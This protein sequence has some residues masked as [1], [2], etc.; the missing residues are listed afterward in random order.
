M[1][2][3][4]IFCLLLQSCSYGIPN[5]GPSSEA[6][7]TEFKTKMNGFKARALGSEKD[8]KCSKEKLDEDFERLM[9]SV[10]K[11]SC[12]Q[13][14][15]S[16]DK[17]EFSKNSCPKIKTEGLFDRVVKKTIQ[18]EKAK[19]PLTY[20]QQK[21]DPEF[22]GL[23]TEAGTY[24]KKI[25]E[26][27]LE[28][29]YP[30]NTRIDLIAD[31]VENVLMPIR[32]LVVIKR[33]Y[34][35]K[36]EDGSEYF[37]NLQ[38]SLPFDMTHDLNTQQMGIL[39][40]GRN[41]STTPTYMEITKGKG[42]YGYQLAFSATDIIRHDVITLL[43]A[44]T[45]KNYVLAMKWMTLH[46][47]LSQ[48]SLYDTM[49]DSKDPVVIPNSCQNQLNGNLPAL[50]KFKNEEGMGDQFLES[51]IASHG[52]AYKKDDTAFLDYYIEN[53]KK[54][55]TQEGYSGLIPF[56][57]YKNAKMS[58]KNAGNNRPQFDDI[59]H[60]DAIM[61]VKLPEAMREF[62]G[63]AKNRNT[64]KKEKITYVG[65]EEFKSILGSYKADE[66][67]EYKSLNG[68]T[69]QIYPGKQ[70]LSPFLFELMKQNGF[71]D[72][73][74][75]ITERLK[76]K[77]VGRKALI[78]FPGM[79]SAPVWRDWSLRV[80]ADLFYQNQNLPT[81]SDFHLITRLH[82]D[83][84]KTN[85]V[86][87]ANKLCT[88]NQ[89]QGL[90]NFLSEFRSGEKY[91]PTRRLEERQFQAIYPLLGFIWASLR[92]DTEFLAEAKPFELNFLLEQMSVGNPWARLKF[93]Y[94]I[95]LDLLEYQREGIDPVYESKNGVYKTQCDLRDVKLKYEHIAEAGKI[96]GL[97][98][99]L[100]FNF[101]EKILSSDE[102]KFIWKNIVADFDHRNAQLFSVTSGDKDFYKIV[103]DVSY[104]TI[105]DEKSALNTGAN[106]SEKTRQE[107]S[108]VAKSNEA[109]IGDFFLKLYKEKNNIEKQQKLYEDFSKINGIDTVY[110]VK[111][112]F[113]AVDESYKKPIYKD[114]LKQAARARKQ[115]IM[116]HLQTFCAMD[117]NN[118]KEL[119]NI[120][121]SASKAQNE[122][123]QAAGLP[124]IPENVLKDI[125]EMSPE[126]FRDM[127]WGIGSG[128]A[129]MAAIAIG[130]ACTWGTGGLCLP[131]AATMVAAGVSSVGIQIKL[132]G[133]ELERKA[134]ADLS[135]KKVK[136]ME[137]LGF[138]NAGSSDEVH[139]GYIWAVVEAA[140]IVPMMGV[141]GRSVSLGPKLAAISARAI[142]QQT[143]KLAFKTA[144]KTAIAEEEAR[145]ASY[146]LRL[147]SIPKMLGLDSKSIDLAKIK[148]DKIRELYISKEI[149]LD[150]MLSRIGKV[151]DPIRRAKLAYAKTI[152]SE[153]GRV[154]VKN[155]EL[156][157]TQTAR[158]VSDYFAGNAS[159]MLRLIK[160]YSGETLSRSIRIMNEINAPE[161]IQKRIPILGGLKD[162]FLRMRNESLAKNAS[163]IL[164][165]EKELAGVGNAPGNLE[166]YV[167]K[168]IDDLT[169]IF[170]DI[171]MR[172]R[173]LLYIMQ[174]Q[175]MPDINF[176]EGRKFPILSII[177]EGQTMKKIFTARARLV[178]ESYKADAR[179][180]FKLKR[181]VQS[182]TTFEAF[183][184]FQYS[185]A[186]MAN[187][188]TGAET[189][190]IMAEYHN[191][192]EKFT[193]KLF[194]KFKENGKT[195][196]YQNFKE[197]ITNAVSIKDRATAEAIWTSVPADELMGMK[198]VSELAHKAVYEL[199]NY[200][201]VDSFQ[202]YLNAL[203]ILVINRTPAV[204][205]IM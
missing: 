134:E 197:L 106:I 60:F 1:K 93:G 157:N 201:D 121:Y 6:D 192:E 110:K 67:A 159:D 178:Y 175:G 75:L 108:A 84:F 87:V 46:M 145:S 122:L 113:L 204:L 104:K 143:G 205:E 18:E 183:K 118:H 188:K 101:A 73:S 169:E 167:L 127:W 64:G 176:Y 33:A 136:I 186:E 152:R 68:E 81:N 88:G 125:N 115:Q 24:L 4:I 155:R 27:S 103:E 47:M 120:F 79:Y 173:E 29:N 146:L 38:P 194:L 168:N 170:M 74:Q 32:D 28:E 179:A 61:S 69:K 48:V 30:L 163:K 123:N 53:V 10:K 20:F 26:I 43:K 137:D 8:A 3:L 51:I 129:G 31:Y 150:E 83:K 54:D 202:N 97:D 11:D 57:N 203:R 44:P 77:F 162:W 90:A 99:P 191:L 34:L 147:D 196:D 154:T 16:I 22:I 156:V 17:E 35:P 161:R 21:L 164:R 80:L 49:L 36:E 86:F 13:S 12:A 7:F 185:V 131:L 14:T 102:K 91:I 55:P 76:K 112:N 126:E 37:I 15:F 158:V 78:D 195:M 98:K 124:T 85:P 180:T 89:V 92:N 174:A 52:L 132:T 199:S 171:P 70:N 45:S 151:L 2:Y 111:V 9:S 82:C 138:A 62:Q 144:V 63:Q 72:Y 25:N 181:Y 133:N 139:R 58:S 117:V 153:V 135:E 119:K 66:I 172:K 95:A 198:E 149:T 128:L 42:G 40:L 116:S 177:S 41:P 96:L 114:L 109:Q 65:S 193:Q 130:T 160:S 200:K 184:S 187:N 189:A 94:M 166:A 39:T 105:L 141:A 19:L 107:I 100:T 50:F 182:E 71:S 59:A 56:E 5:R 23:V 140:S 190:K 165:I 142:A 148:I